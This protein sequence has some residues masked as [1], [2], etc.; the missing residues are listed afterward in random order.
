MHGLLYSIAL[1]LV[2]VRWNA[3]TSLNSSLPSL[4]PSILGSSSFSRLFGELVDILGNDSSYKVRIHTAALLLTIVNATNQSAEVNLK[5]VKRVATEAQ[6]N[7]QDQLEEG[8][9]QAKERRH[10]EILIKKVRD[11]PS[12]FFKLKR[13]ADSDFIRLSAGL[14][15]FPAPSVN[16][17]NFI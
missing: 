7:L 10:V 12:R 9:V 11:S 15:D 1:S 13:P 5:K 16:I 14:F 8:R 4:T 2:Q 17:R 3:C 6:G